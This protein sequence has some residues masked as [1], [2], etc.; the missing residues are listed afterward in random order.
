M[1]E[2]GAAGQSTVGTV[3]TVMSPT[4]KIRG[5]V[6]PD[7]PSASTCATY[8]GLTLFD[9][10]KYLWSTGATLGSLGLILYGISLN[11]YVLPTPP[12]AAYI[13]AVCTMIMLFY[14]E[15]SRQYL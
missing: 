8:K 13:I 1:Q 12:P 6:H 10:F 4:E 7:Y 5:R 9:L 3:A 14:L 2:T 11:A 15:V